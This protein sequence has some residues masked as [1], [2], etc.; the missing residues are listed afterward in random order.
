MNENTFNMIEV[1]LCARYILGVEHHIHVKDSPGWGEEIKKGQ[2]QKQLDLCSNPGKRNH[3]GT[4]LESDGGVD[5][6]G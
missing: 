4:V 1:L 5:G 2:D 3:G 6:N